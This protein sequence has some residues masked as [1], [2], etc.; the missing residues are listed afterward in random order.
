MQSHYN[1]LNREE[2]REMAPLCLEEGVGLIPWSPLAR[3]KLARPWKAPSSTQRVRVDETARHLYAGSEAADEQIV[4][5]VGEVAG[6]RGV[7]HAQVALA[8]LLHQPGVTAP[9]I[10]ATQ[11]GHLDDAV[12]SLDV[13]LEPAEVAALEADYVPHRVVGFE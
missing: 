5:R 8:W 10:G 2:E 9:I 7:P 12:A 13:N 1:L 11:L 4:R 3:G 6:A